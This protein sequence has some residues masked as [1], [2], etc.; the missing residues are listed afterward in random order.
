MSRCRRENASNEGA[1][2]V[3]CRDD[4]GAYV[5]AELN[6]DR[7]VCCPSLDSMRAIVCY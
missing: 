2:D 1:V 3:A 7:L 4:A 6:S 5:V